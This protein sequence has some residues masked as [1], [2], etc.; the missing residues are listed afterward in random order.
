MNSRII[1]NCQIC[2]SAKLK[3]IL[4]LGYIAPVNNVIDYK[5]NNILQKKYQAKLLKCN[6]C[7]LVQLSSIL[8]KKIIFPKT[9][10]YTSSTTKILSDNFK[11]LYLKIKKNFNFKEQDLVVDIGSNDGNLLDKFKTYFRVVGITPELIGKLA[12]KKGV[13]TLIRYFDKKAVDIILN[14]YGKASVITATNV[15]AH[16]DDINYV[17]RQ[18]KRLMKKDSIFISESHYLLPLIKNI[19]YDTV[20]HEHMRYYSLKSLNY[21]FKKHNLQIFDAENIPTHGGSIR[22]YACNIKKY[23]VK[24]SVNKILNT[25]KKYLTFKNFDNKVLDTKINLLKILNNLKKKNKSIGGISAPSRA[26]T[27]MNYTGI[28]YDLVK[29]IFEIKGSKKIGNFV[30]G[31]S[32]PIIE[33]KINELNKFNYLIIFSWHI[34]KEIIRNLK[35]KGFKGKFILPLPNPKIVSN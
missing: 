25:E 6:R 3:D 18:I 15:F 23:K 2:N 10:P 16:M 31:T 11:E 32:I 13:P 34:K 1:K 7:D 30:P 26:T 19:Q 27:L 17:I 8:D 33:E 12:I 4:N 29:C 21:L 14:K 24:N 28:D 9:Y 20:Y 22:V 35:R 5:S